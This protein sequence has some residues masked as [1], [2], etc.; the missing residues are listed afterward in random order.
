MP[1]YKRRTVEELRDKLEQ[2]I[3]V[4]GDTVMDA[5]TIDTPPGDPRGPKAVEIDVNLMNL[6]LLHV[7]ARFN[8]D[9]PVMATP[10]GPR[11]LAKAMEKTF[12]DILEERRQAAKAFVGES[13]LKN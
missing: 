2:L 11:K 8:E 13:G 7:I 3:E 9:A 1:D 6:A 4:V 12:A 10:A 5:F